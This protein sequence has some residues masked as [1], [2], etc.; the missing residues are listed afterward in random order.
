MELDSRALYEALKQLQPAIERGPLP[1][2]SHVLIEADGPMAK[3]R[4]TNL[5]L[6]IEVHVTA[7]TEQGEAYCLPAKTLLETVQTFNGLCRI[8]ANSDRTWQVTIENG[9]FVQNLTGM[10]CSDYPAWTELQDLSFYPVSTAE[11]LDTCGSVVHAASREGHRYNLNAVLFDGD[12]KRL[13]ATDGHRVKYQAANWLGTGTGTGLVPIA[14]LQ[15]AIKALKLSR[16]KDLVVAIEEKNLVV[17][18]PNTRITIRLM[19]GEPFKDFGFTLGT[20]PVVTMPR[21]SVEKAMRMTRILLNTR[22]PHLR[23]HF[24]PF[25]VQFMTESDSGYARTEIEGLVPPELQGTEIDV[26]WM[27]FSQA[28]KAAPAIVPLSVAGDFITMGNEFIYRIKPK[29]G[30]VS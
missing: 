2:L 9:E 12:N 30:G 10:D 13:V 4:A 22:T 14:G 28:I 21:K 8:T 24:R 19:D 5:E 17:N 27:Y 25:R 3:L 29:A 16:D 15:R 11:F 18:G 7:E 20:L 23:L 6:A 26:N 1:I